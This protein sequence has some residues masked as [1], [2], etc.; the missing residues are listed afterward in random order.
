MSKNNEGQPLAPRKRSLTAMT[1]TWLAERM[2]KAERVRCAVE[3]GEYRV[4]SEDLA[5]SIVVKVP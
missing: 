4:N 2:R 3:K 5:R 1:L